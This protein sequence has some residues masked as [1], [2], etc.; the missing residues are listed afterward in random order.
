MIMESS[1][2][3]PLSEPEALKIV[4]DFY[5]KHGFE[6]HRI[7][8]D[9]LPQG[10]KAPDFLAKNVENRFLCEVKAPRLV[11]DDVT[12]LYKWDTTFNKIRARIHTATKQFREYDPKVTY[13]RVL[14]FTSNHPLLNWTS[15][16]H[17]I[18]GAIKIGD[19]V[20]RDYNG[21]F[22]VK[23]TTKELEYIDIYV[24]M[25]INYMNRRSIIEMSFY[26]S[27]KNAKDPII[28]KLLMSLKPYPEENIKRPNFGALLK[29]L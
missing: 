5:S 17:N 25:Q 22:F 19:N 2:I 23:E 13:P 6:V 12:K 9:K 26:V 18:V 11:L 15:F 3:Q 7:D 14:V 16:V 20:I 10:Q 27:M 28:Q 4:N 29:K 24:W 1:Q 8:T 21:K